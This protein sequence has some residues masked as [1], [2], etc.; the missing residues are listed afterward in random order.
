[1]GTYFLLLD[2]NNYF[3]SKEA[4]NYSRGREILRKSFPP[5]QEYIPIYLHTM[6]P[7]GSVTVT[8]NVPTIL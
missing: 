5:F 8:N 1:M 3:I 4:E 7:L 6:I 2:Q